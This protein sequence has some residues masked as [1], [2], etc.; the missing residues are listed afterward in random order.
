MGRGQLRGTGLG[1]RRGWGKEGVGGDKLRWWGRGGG[2]EGRGAVRIW[3]A[4][5]L[6]PRQPSR[7]GFPSDVCPTYPSVVPGQL[8]RCPRM[9]TG[10]ARNPSG[11]VRSRR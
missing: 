3:L 7:W 5:P 10:H 4:W 11:V 9:G 2:V 8:T 6:A 1:L